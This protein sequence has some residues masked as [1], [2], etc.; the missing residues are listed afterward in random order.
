MAATTFA[1]HSASA[2]TRRPPPETEPTSTARRRALLVA[3]RERHE[4][5]RRAPDRD[6]AWPQPRA[7]VRLSGSARRQGRLLES[8]RGATG[9]H[10]RGGDRLLEEDVLPG[11]F[12][13]TRRPWPR[14]SGS[15]NAAARSART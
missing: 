3:A 1:S 15:A 6:D 11:S 7:R 8:H 2:L 4:H 5:L 10:A 12:A 13:R 9:D 14:T